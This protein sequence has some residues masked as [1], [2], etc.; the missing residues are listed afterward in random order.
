MKKTELPLHKNDEFDMEITAVSS[1][2]V[3]IGR[4]LGVAVFVPHTAVGDTVRCH[5]IKV[6]SSYAVAKC[7]QLLSPSP[8][9]IADDCAVGHTCG[10]CVYRHVT[11]AAEL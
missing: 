2:G 5:I 8:Q 3:G 7:L 1:D 11:Y 6:T 4:H 9:R 10:G